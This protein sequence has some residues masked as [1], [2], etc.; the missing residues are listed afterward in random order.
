MLS[1]G[2]H[3]AD[4]DLGGVVLPDMWAGAQRWGR[5]LSCGLLF[6]SRQPPLTNRQLNRLVRQRAGDGADIRPER[7]VPI[8]ALLWSGRA[9]Y[10]NLRTLTALIR[11]SV[12]AQMAASGNVNGSG[13]LEEQD[14]PS[15]KAAM[16][17][18]PGEVR[19]WRAA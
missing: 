17:A 16:A 9:V 15:E 5:R 4:Q 2:P 13:L 3:Y 1:P 14:A 7:R 6:R 19:T 8:R 10:I 11:R 12:G 18:G